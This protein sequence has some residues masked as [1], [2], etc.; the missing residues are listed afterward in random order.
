MREW[1]RS[2]AFVT[3]GARG[4]GLGIARALG[5]RGVR[6]ALADVDAPAL[7]CAAGELGAEAHLLDVRDRA[8]FQKAAD[9]AERALGP[10]DLLFNN[11]GIVPHAPVTELTYDKWDLALAVNLTGVINGIQTFL[12]RMI[13]RAGGY[14]VNT[15]SAAGLVSDPNVLYA[16]A[17][18]AVVG[19][20]ESLRLNVAAHGI[21]V[22]VLCPGPVDT[23]IVANTRALAADVALHE[24][25]VP[26]VEEFLS[27]GPGIDEVGEMVL[28]GMEKRSPWI[29]TGYDVRPHLE[30]RTAAL[31]AAL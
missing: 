14:V 10:V 9:E 29:F 25:H 31:L 21:E 30:Q 26:A 28:A 3:G 8:A 24:E 23:D 13:E 20:S 19:L 12:P 4:I 27:S 5:K 2:A 16:T 6:L 17:K 22:S 7:E 15:A 1:T 11:A 18:F